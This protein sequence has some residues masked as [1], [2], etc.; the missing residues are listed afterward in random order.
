MAGYRIDAK[1]NVC[2]IDELNYLLV[3]E[4]KVSL[5]GIESIYYQLARL[6]Q[7]TASK[8]DPEP[9]IIARAIA[10]FYQNNLRRKQVG[11]PQLESK[12][13][14]TIT[15]IGTTLIF[16]RIPITTAL[17]NAV[18]TASYPAEETVVRRFIPPFPNP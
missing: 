8:D 10:A 6:F 12:Y 4:G 16:Y 9:Q 7:C 17:L 11:S 5:L 3:R 13:I 2:L 18:V 1:A 14:P 15:V